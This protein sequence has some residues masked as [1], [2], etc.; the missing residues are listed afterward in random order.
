ML[1]NG[2]KRNVKRLV[3][4]RNLTLNVNVP[5]KASY[6]VEKFNK[7]GCTDASKCYF[8]F[9]KCF[10]NMSEDVIWSIYEDSTHNPSV[11]SPIKY[12]IGA[13]RNQMR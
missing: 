8:F 13:C 4:K 3:S 6:L 7:I 11:K 1:V 2:E 12:F 10:T 5:S 9:M